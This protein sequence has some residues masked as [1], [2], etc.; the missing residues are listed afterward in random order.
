MAQTQNVPVLVLKE[1][2]SRTKGRDAQKAN[3][4]AAVTLAE[5]IRSSL[6]PKGMDK[7]LVSS[8][9]DVTISNDGA[10]I[11]KEMDVQHPAAKMLVEVAKTQDA[12]VGD[13]TTTAVILA[14]ALLKKA[15]DLLDQDIHPTVIIEGYKKSMEKALDVIDKLA[16]EVEPMDKKRLKE[17]AIT[18]LSGKSVVTGHFERLA[19]LVVDAVVQVAEKT[20]DKYTVDLDNVKLEKK[21]GETLDDT[22]LVKGVVLDKEVVH[23]GMP[24]QVENAKIAII[25]TAL[26]IEK[27][28]ITAKIN[29]TSPD[30]MKNFLDEEASMIKEMVDKVVASGA[31]V[32]IVQ[33]GIDDIAQHYL[34]KKNIMALRRAKRSDIENLAKA[35]GAR[36]VTTLDDLSSKDLGFA[37]NVEERR[38]GKDKMVFVE[39]CK[40]PKS[41][42]ILIRGGTDRMVDEAERSLH[43]AK[44][45]VRNVIQDPHL[46][47]GGGAPEEEVATKLR[48]FA[49]SFSGREQLAVL[50]FAEAIEEVPLTLAENSGLD[51]VDILVEIRAAHSRGEK[52]AGVNVFSGKISDMAKANVLEPA[53]V[54][55]QAIKSAT[56]AA[57]TLLKI[58]DVIAA[59]A[60]KGG[61][62]GHAPGMEGMPP[63]MGGMGGM[64]GM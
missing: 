59:S 15:E 25:D 56:E 3:I 21:K 55:K 29:I 60:P 16:T 8:F 33:K 52:S 2:T 13:G 19:E 27:T 10:T 1:G 48:E 14:G 17:V 26:E 44:C 37:K 53:S 5:T 35:S 12:E 41:V 46:V 24:K 28:E 63:G 22:Q 58:D 36:I 64:G 61:A 39:G 42:T 43:D 4:M 9:G 47:A 38:V 31:N 11:V 54:K 18:S 34:A 7:M 40:N 51:P 62:G 49:K 30:Q 57:I 6:G 20:G 45:V 32:V 23:P 50:K